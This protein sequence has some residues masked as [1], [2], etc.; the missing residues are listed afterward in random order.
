TLD[1]WRDFLDVRDVCA[2]Y[3]AAI[4]RFD[5]LPAGS[6]LNLASGHPRRVGDVLDEL[7][8]LSGVQARVE[9]TPAELRPTD[10][11]ET[12]C[13]AGQ[14]RRLLDWTPVVP[15]ERTLRDILDAWRRTERREG[16]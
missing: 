9:E 15:W 14:L 10:L 5:A 16:S 2:A 11:R 6:A 1:R 13:S 8:R 12:A 7:L 4:G 3:V